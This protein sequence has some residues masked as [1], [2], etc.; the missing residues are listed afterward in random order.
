MDQLIKISKVEGRGHSNTWKWLG[1][2]ALL[3]PIFDIFQ[4]HWVPFVCTTRYYWPS[5]SAEKNCL[6]L[7]HLVP[8]LIWP[9]VGVFYFYPNLSFDTF[10]AICTNFLLDFR[11]CWP[12]FSLLNIWSFLH[13]ILQNRGSCWVHFFIGHSK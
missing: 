11:S 3:P 10:N 7:S 13:L 1:T 2:S 5:L 8:E 6:S 12:P 4:S 9:K